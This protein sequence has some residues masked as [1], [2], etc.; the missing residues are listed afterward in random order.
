MSI[1]SK[2]LRLL[3]LL[4]LLLLGL[5]AIAVAHIVYVSSMVPTK[6]LGDGR[7]QVGSW[8]LGIVSARGTWIIEGDRHGSPLNMWE[9][10]CVREERLCWAAKAEITAGYLNAELERLEIKRWDN[11][12]L[13]F[14]TDATCVSY[15]YVINRST[16]RLT[17]RRVKKATTDERAD[18]LC[19]DVEPELR[20]SFVEG[21]TVV[22]ELRHLHAPTA[23]SA[24]AASAWLFFILVWMVRIVRRY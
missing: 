10:E 20:L 22:S 5:S 3:G 9:L 8:E 15:V 1:I 24:A 23:Y 6:I 19:G 4:L 13:E 16:E 12:T 18:A 7:V 17:G 11:A 21:L 2:T 14:V